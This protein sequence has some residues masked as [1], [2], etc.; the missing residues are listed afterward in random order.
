[1]DEDFDFS[2][3]MQTVALVNDLL[4]MLGSVCKECAAVLCGHELLMNVVTGYR[5]SPRC[6]SCLSR[7]LGRG[8][9]EVRDQL[10]QYILH[11]ECR[12]AAWLWASQQ[13]GTAA[14]PACLWSSIEV[15]KESH[16]EAAKPGSSDWSG[17]N[18]ASDAE[19]NAGNMACGE[20][21]LELRLRLQA[22]NSGQ[23]LKLTATD[24]GAPEDLP[25]WC[26]L[27]GHKLVSFNQPEY[28]IQRKEK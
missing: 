24:D 19:W 9:E 15:E 22:M 27:T 5:N 26:R 25:A 6:L 17:P 21:V 23:I 11:R 28:W 16:Q 2:E 3:D 4:R 12:R 7:Q 18:Q 14:L 1:M 20:L 10:Y 13:E 8:R